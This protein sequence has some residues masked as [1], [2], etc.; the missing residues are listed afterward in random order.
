MPTALSTA[1]ELAAT[2]L[3]CFPIGSNKHPTTGNGFYAASIDPAVLA[4][5][6]KRFP[7]SLIGVR[8][9][10]VSGLDVLDVDTYKPSGRAWWAEHRYRIG[11]T[12]V[13]RTSRGGLH[14][15]FRHAANLHNSTGRISH[16]VDTR[17]DGG[18]IVWWPCLVV[19]GWS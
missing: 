18:Y 10:A 16:G 8:T 9:G 7:G 4:D 14:L 19:V 15:Y 5:L 3:P 11:K 13:H 1:I 12:R 17:G 2:G 6:W